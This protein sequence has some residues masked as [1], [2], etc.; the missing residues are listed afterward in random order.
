MTRLPRSMA[1]QWLLAAGLLGAIAWALLTLGHLDPSGTWTRPPW[2]VSCGQPAAGHRWSSSSS[3]L[4]KDP[5]AT[6][7]IAID[8][9]RMPPPSGPDHAFERQSDLTKGSPREAR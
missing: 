6:A 7:I 3:T 1:A 9:K 5:T 2:R 8:A 4:P